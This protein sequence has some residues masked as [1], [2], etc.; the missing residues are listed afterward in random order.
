M[1]TAGDDLSLCRVLARGRD[2]VTASCNASA[3][4]VDLTR[5]WLRL[6]LVTGIAG[7]D[8]WVSGVAARLSAGL[9]VTWMTS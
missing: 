2:A 3:F 5:L 1:L 9:S 8:V 4:D 6:G 7:R